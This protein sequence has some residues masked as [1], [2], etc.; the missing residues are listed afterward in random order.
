MAASRYDNALEYI[1]IGL[2]YLGSDA[3][4][5]SLTKF[6]ILEEREVLQATSISMLSLRYY[7]WFGIAPP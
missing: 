4:K 3:A 1:E 5:R 2:Q 6:E 7:T